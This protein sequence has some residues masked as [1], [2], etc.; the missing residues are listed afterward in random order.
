MLLKKAGKEMTVRAA[1]KGH[2]RPK[3]AGNYPPWLLPR[4]GTNVGGAAPV[5]GFGRCGYRVGFVRLG[6]LCSLDGRMRPSPHK[7][8]WC[9]ASWLVSKGLGMGWL[10]GQ[11]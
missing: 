9:P 10:V 6:S 3:R 1:G 7:L 11:G 8:G 4:Q 5:A 2:V